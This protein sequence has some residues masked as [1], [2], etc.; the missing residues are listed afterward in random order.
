[1]TFEKGQTIRFSGKRAEAR[2]TQAV[3]DAPGRVERIDETCVRIL[4][5][6]ILTLVD[7]PATTSRVLHPE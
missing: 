1:M 6:S 7:P 5:P 3:K 2:A 4:V